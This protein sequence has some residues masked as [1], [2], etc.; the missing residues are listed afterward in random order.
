M[1]LPRRR[2]P[3]QVLPD[4]SLRPSN[5]RRDIRC[6][7]SQAPAAYNLHPAASSLLMSRDGDGQRAET[8]GQKTEDS[9]LTPPGA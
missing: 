7:F 8:L 4:R 9:G 5:G 2:E 6:W 3:S 1:P